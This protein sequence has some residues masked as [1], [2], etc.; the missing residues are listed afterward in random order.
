M[1]GQ[2][3]NELAV[4]WRPG[5]HFASILLVVRRDNQATASEPW[6]MSGALVNCG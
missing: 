2:N 3:Q 1:H 4:E 5:Q 6:R